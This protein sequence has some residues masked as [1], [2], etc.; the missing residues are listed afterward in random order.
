VSALIK[1]VHTIHDAQTAHKKPKSLSLYFC[2]LLC[3]EL[4]L[5]PLYEGRTLL[6]VLEN[7]MLRKKYGLKMRESKKNREHGDE[8]H[9][10]CSSYIAVVIQSNNVRW[11]RHRGHEI[12]IV[13]GKLE[14]YRPY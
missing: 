1:L 5:G 6:Q 13:V 10:C 4:K 2:L 12:R 11:V 9:N 8:I 3:I 7:R 14:T